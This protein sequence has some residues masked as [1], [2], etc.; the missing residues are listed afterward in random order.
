MLEKDVLLLDKF[1]MKMAKNAESESNDSDKNYYGLVAQVVRDFVEVLEAHEEGEGWI[2]FDL[3]NLVSMKVLFNDLKDREGYRTYLKYVLAL[4]MSDE[5]EGE[6]LDVLDFYH[7]IYAVE[8]GL[9]MIDSLNELK[10]EAVD[11]D[12]YEEALKDIQ[13]DYIYDD[14]SMDCEIN[15]EQMER[16]ITHICSQIGGYYNIE[17]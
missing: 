1:L 17:A 8:F 4:M 5:F 15:E 16:Y 10:V 6:E 12:Y 3:I 14:F 11:K 2:D 7:Q 13:N 9:P